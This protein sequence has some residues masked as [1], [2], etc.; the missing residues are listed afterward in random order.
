MNPYNLSEFE[1][2]SFILVLV[3]I[4]AFYFAFPLFDQVSVPGPAK[5]LLS[6]LTA[7]VLFP[8]IGAVPQKIAIE[9]LAWL[10]IK[11]MFI[12]LIMAFIAKLFFFS[13]SICGEIITSIIGLSSSQMFNPTFGSSVMVLERFQLY[14]GTLFFLAFNGHHIFINGMAKSFEIVP[15]VNQT[16][17][18]IVFK[19]IGLFGEQVL[20]IGVQLSAPIMATILFL[21]IGMGIVGRAVPQIN[22]LVT[23][24]SVNILVGFA[25]MIVSVP[26]AIV[27]MKD[28]L[29][30]VGELLFKVLK[31]L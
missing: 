28:S 12:G 2:L 29:N 18:P 14:I 6:L 21:N 7:F 31:Q 25:I 8:V 1:I 22:V 16:I 11:E 24:W 4:S 30:M 5:I 27:S 13:L 17:N 23:S 3:R 26:L 15:I 20:T 10:T 19:D 9:M